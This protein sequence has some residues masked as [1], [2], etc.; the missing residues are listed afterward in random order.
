MRKDTKPKD[1]LRHLRNSFAHGNF[2]K[3]QKNKKQCIVIENIDSGQLKAKG[4]LPLDKLKGLVS[5][6][7]GC[8][9]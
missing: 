6:A 4:F 2:K 1:T 9:V 8:G 3:R 5:A 7:S